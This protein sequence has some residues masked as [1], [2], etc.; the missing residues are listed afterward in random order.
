MIEQNFIK[1]FESSFRENWDLPA[2]TNYNKGTTITYGEGAQIIAKLHLLFKEI[3]IQQGDKIALIGRNTPHW[4]LSYVAVVT[5]GAI[6]VPILQ[7]FKPNDIH[8]IVNHSDARLLFCSNKHWDSL[9][10][11]KMEDL[12]G[13]FTLEDFR[14]VHQKEESSI[15]NY[16]AQLEQE[17]TALYPEG[18]TQNDVAY[19]TRENTELAM[20][21]YTS[22]TTGF[23]K[24][25][26]ISGNALAGN[27]MFGIE[28][29]LV[30]RGGRSLAFLPLAHAYGM[31]FDF[32]TSTCAGA[33]TYLLN[34][35]PSPKVLLKAFQVIKPTIIFTVPLIL[36]KIYKKQLRPSISTRGMRLAL[37]IPII[38]E[39]IYAQINKKLT[40]A[41]GGEFKEIIV[42]GAPLNKEVE[43]FLLKIGFRFTV[44]YGMTECAPLISYAP[45]QHFKPS[46]VGRVLDT[47]EVKIDSEDPYRIVGEIL[48]RGENLMSGYY[49][50]AEITK[51]TFDD[52]GWMRTGD[53]GTI[54]DMGNIYIKGRSKS[55]FLSA[56]G[57]NIY[58]EEIEAKLNNLPFVMESLVIEKNNKLIGLIYPDYDA[59]DAA[60]I[61]H[62]DL[63]LIMEE[64]KSAI[65]QKVASYEGISKIVLYPNEFEKTPKKSIKR[66]L[67][68]NLN[69]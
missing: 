55:M 41:F 42:G 50:N 34:K 61:A 27:I 29:H 59:V 11:E 4:T 9:E 5:Y 30:E 6:I 67:Y 52:E 47:M 39:K 1:L 24:G 31:A 64:N 17:F 40:E 68:A 44:G 53:V 54:D 2:Y 69:L 33:H 57:Q 46:S 21:N 14:C 36:E 45:H 49:K 48:V 26:M 3:G 32:L 28:S 56:S 12:Q 19:A 18:F 15:L 66:Y 25:V 58:P 8:H 20:I 38:D 37:N 16:T 23:S 35:I 62:D 65:N 63:A 13:I 43:D 22:G 60:E 51:A 10:E 7:D